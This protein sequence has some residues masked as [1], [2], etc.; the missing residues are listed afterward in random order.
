MNEQTR[1]ISIKKV[2]EIAGICKTEVYKRIDAS[3]TRKPK[4]NQAV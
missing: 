2:C 3:Q 4:L 1:L